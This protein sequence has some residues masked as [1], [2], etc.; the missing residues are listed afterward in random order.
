MAWL[1]L[2]TVALS[3]TCASLWLALL[4]YPVGLSEVF[5]RVTRLS[6]ILA[7][8]TPGAT[9]LVRG[10]RC[11]ASVATV[12]LLTS[13]VLDAVIT[14]GLSMTRCVRRVLSWLVTA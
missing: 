14:I 2:L 5:W 12:L 8:G 3:M 1:V 9:I 4:V 6:S 11:L 13:P 10:N 7:L